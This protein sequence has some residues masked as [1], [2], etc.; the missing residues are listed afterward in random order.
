MNIN[1]FESIKH[2]LLA[3]SAIILLSFSIHF[4]AVLAEPTLTKKQKKLLKQLKLPPGFKIDYYATKISGP[5]SMA[6]G[7][8]GTV[9]VGTRSH[10]T[11]YALIDNN[12][13]GFADEKIIVA[14]GL[15]MP[16][17]IAFYQ[18]DL[19]VAEVHRILRFGDI[20]S[21]LR[22]IPKPQVVYNKL[23]TETHHG[24]RYIRFGPDNKLYIAIGAPCNNCNKKNYATINRIDLSSGKVEIIARGVRNSVG[25]D[26]HP[27]TKEFWFTD[28]GRDMMGDDIPP[29][30]IN[31]LKKLSTHFGFPYCH[32]GEVIDPKYGQP[33]ACK[34]YIQ[35]EVKLGAHVAPLGLRFYTGKRFPNKF[36]QGFFVA[37]HGSWNRSSKSGY[38]VIF[39]PLKN[40]K[41]QTIIPFVTGWLKG[42]KSLGRPVDFL[43]MPDG[44]LL[45]SDDYANVIYR[46]SYR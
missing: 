2:L 3:S 25:F 30:E 6:I 36:K 18:G 33:G 39:V 19:Y 37:E 8:K 31:R 15:N 11:V 17:G 46:I 44:S 10:G 4:P 7:R 16:N 27:R 1:R 34:R 43:N 38:R 24:W 45:V 26:F 14:K 32:G 20:E 9:F 13:D 5:R 29:D 42:E 35:P 22:Q 23:P 21:K 28:N 40:N 41:T 12:R